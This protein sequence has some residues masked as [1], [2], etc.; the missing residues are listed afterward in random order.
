MNKE[1]IMRLMMAAGEKAAKIRSETPN[2]SYHMFQTVVYAELAELIVKECI[3]IADE[4]DCNWS[5]VS[6][7]L[8]EHFGIE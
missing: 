7:V 3:Q 5:G 8:K 2:F 4:A 1:I 6:A